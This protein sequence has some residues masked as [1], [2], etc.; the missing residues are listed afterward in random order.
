MGAPNMMLNMCERAYRIELSA[1]MLRRAPCRRNGTS[2]CPSM[3]GLGPDQLAACR[4]TCEE[5][6]SHAEDPS[7]VPLA[8]VSSRGQV[9]PSSYM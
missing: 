1:A 9:F 8:L 3:P 6:G 5:S 2:R 7:E 4:L